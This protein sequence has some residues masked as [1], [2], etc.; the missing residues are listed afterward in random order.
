MSSKPRWL[1]ALAATATLTLAAGARADEP[2]P[3]AAENAT[4]PLLLPRFGE[5]QMASKSDWTFGFHGYARGPLRMN[6]KFSRQPYLVDDNYFLSGF[7][8]TRLSETEWAEA[9]LSAQKGKTRFVLGLFASQF[10][11]WSETTLQGQGGVA[12]AFVE[13]EFD[14]ASIA[15]LSIRA[16]MFWDREGF[17]QTYDTYLLGRMHV[18]GLRLVLKMWDKWY[19]KLGFGA[20]AEVINSN[21][22]FTPVGWFKSG[23]DLGW[24]DAGF[25]G[26]FSW[27]NDSERKFSIIK[28]GAMRVLGVEARAAIPH[29][30]NL[31]LLL[32]H[33]RADKVAF[34][35]NAFE[36][37]H[38]TGG[39]GLTQSFFGADSEN[40]TGDALM[41]GF[42]LD[43]NLE[44]TFKPLFGE[45][46]G[47]AVR[48]LDLRLFGMFAGVTSKQRSDDPLKNFDK[49]WYVKWG[50]EL[51]YRFP[52]KPLEWLF[53]SLRYDRVILDTDHDSMAFRAMTPRVGITPIK[54]FG[55]D[56]FLSYSKYWYGSN[57]RLRP[58]QIPGDASV[59]TP[60][61]SML[62]IQAQVSW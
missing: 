9:F 53:V 50:T 30:G 54:D 59:T 61:D 51:F 38:S 21:Q 42:E 17:I 31:H 40:G 44:R 6:S 48:G 8:Y 12:T 1:A 4:P 29:T 45:S 15:K 5:D 60:D 28:D 33:L 43:W 22:G 34:L 11:D 52:M 14:L 58:N 25:F 27:T 23:V 36:V 26:G 16:G 3:R 56:I 19:T 10:S 57:V 2:P 41:G 47:R 24:L 49:R 55:L 32:S 13:H 46:A 7:A 35:S 20:H 62:K 37:L 39:R 18:A